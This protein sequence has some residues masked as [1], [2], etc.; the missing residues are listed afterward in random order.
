VI[1]VSAV[2]PVALRGVERCGSASRDKKFALSAERRSDYPASIENP[3]G[4]FTSPRRSAEGGG[5]AVQFGSR[6]FG[7]GN[8]NERTARCAFPV[9]V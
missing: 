5:A 6:S 1:G 4:V 7:K 3:I 8:S 2:L 9:G